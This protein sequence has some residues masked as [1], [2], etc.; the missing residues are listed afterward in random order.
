MAA[1]PQ[2]IGVIA[3]PYW[4]EVTDMALCLIKC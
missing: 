4:K 3:Q 1:V 2:T